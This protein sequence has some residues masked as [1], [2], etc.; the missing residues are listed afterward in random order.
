MKKTYEPA[1]Q[2]PQERIERYRAIL[3]VLS[4]EMTVS[5]AA[6][7][8]HLSRNHFQS[9]MHR[10]LAALIE[11]IGNK[12]PGRRSQP[13]AQKAALE[14]TR[15]IQK[16]N[17]R[18]RHRVETTDRLL[19]VA[20]DLLKGRI[21]ARGHRTR[22]KT[23]EKG[24]EDKDEG[25]RACLREAREVRRLGLTASLAAAIAGV[26][27]ATLRRWSLR[28]QHGQRICNRRGPRLRGPL[29]PE[30]WALIKERVRDLRGLAGAASLAKTIGVSRRQ[31]AAV[32]KEEMTAIE[33]ERRRECSRVK[34]ERI[35]VLRGFDQLYAPTWQGTRFALISADGKIPYRTSVTVTERYDTKNIVRAL[36]KD[37]A[38]AGVPLVWRADRFRAHETKPVLDM[39]D[40]NGVLLL[41]GPVHYPRFYGQLERQ[42]REH[43]AWLDA[44]GP[45][46]PGR[47]REEAQRMILSLNTLW[48]RRMLGWLTPEEAWNMETTP[49][50]DRK[51]LREEVTDRAARLARHLHGKPDAT[52]LATRLAIE[53]ALKNHGLLSCQ[54]GG[55]C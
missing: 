11:G 50:V 36:E 24:G 18:L 45:L 46:D 26:A 38:R 1:P 30:K 16:E 28:E 4:G 35:G 54:K 15:R 10:G 53:Q 6:R 44:L 23:Q 49:V 37:F 22:P 17:E 21:E 47:L 19:L 40:R 14:E 52:N 9:L 7:S 43:R 41:H 29:S 3:A 25:E 33:R 51:A 8:L 34:V 12:P 55:W 48:R 42:N 27:P 13:E 31:A 39:L 5:E 20:S 32:K 2:V